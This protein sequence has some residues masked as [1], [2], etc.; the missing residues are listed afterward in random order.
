MIAS[1]GTETSC[2]RSCAAL[3]IAHA[4]DAVSWESVQDSKLSNE[5]KYCT[6]RAWNEGLNRLRL[7]GL[8]SSMNPRGG[9]SAQKGWEGLIARMYFIE[10]P[11]TLLGYI[12]LESWNL[13]SSWLERHDQVWVPANWPFLAH[14]NIET[15]EKNKHLRTES[16]CRAPFF[17]HMPWFHST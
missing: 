6:Y 2:F 10:I 16:L 9:R 11:C 15:S 1:K 17:I 12:W 7:F 13:G 4:K 8:Y 5:Q 14:Q 3:N